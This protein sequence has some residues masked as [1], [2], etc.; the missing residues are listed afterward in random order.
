MWPGRKLELGMSGNPSD[1][2]R[3]AQECRERASRAARPED[4]SAWIRLAEDWE[5]FANSVEQFA[6]QWPPSRDS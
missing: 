2:W 5:I 1:Y 3:K 4:K 6:K